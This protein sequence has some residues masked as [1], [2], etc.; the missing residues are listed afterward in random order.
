MLGRLW[1]QVVV[2]AEPQTVVELVVVEVLDN[3]EISAILS[4][5]EIQRSQF[6]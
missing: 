2:R 5:L 4:S 1:S 6:K 3:T